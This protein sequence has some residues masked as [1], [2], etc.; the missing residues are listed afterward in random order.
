LGRGE[1]KSPDGSVGSKKRPLFYN[2]VIS[3]P[4][5][6]GWA[7]KFRKLKNHMGLFRRDVGAH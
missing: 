6:G 4:A 1:D 3:V 5:W 7:I 2:D